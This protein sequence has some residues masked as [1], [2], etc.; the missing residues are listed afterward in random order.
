MARTLIVEKLP[1]I[2]PGVIEAQL[3][4]GKSGPLGMAYDRAEFMEQRRAMM[5][6]WADYLDKLRQGVQVIPR[7]GSQPKTGR[8]SSRV[9]TPG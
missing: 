4:H 8:F 3:A 2:D 7:I 5:Q 9:T 6:A 1:G